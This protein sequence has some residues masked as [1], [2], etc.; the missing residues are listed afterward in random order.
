MKIILLLLISTISSANDFV[1]FF[2]KVENLT[3]DFVQTVDGKSP[4]SGTLYFARP[5]S[6]KW[7][8]QKP[9]E[10]ILMLNN[11]IITSYDIWLQSAN[12]VPYQPNELIEIFINKPD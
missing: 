8:T 2:N 7:H 1:N 6:I 9:D 12:L 4:S 11:N 3:A 5:D 10:H